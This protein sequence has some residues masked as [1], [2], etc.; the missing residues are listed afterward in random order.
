MEHVLTELEEVVFSSLDSAS[1]TTLHA[2]ELDENSRGALISL[3]EH[4]MSVENLEVSACWHMVGTH[5]CGRVK[6]SE[7]EHGYMFMYPKHMLQ[8]G[9]VEFYLEMKSDNKTL[10]TTMLCI[11]IEPNYHYWRHMCTGS[12]NSGSS[13][14]LTDEQLKTLAD[15]VAGNISLNLE[16]EENGN[17]YL[18]KEN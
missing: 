2:R 8:A 17:L 1:P 3:P 11:E 10:T 16:L 13:A 18:I 15:K 4:Y 14:S 6:L 7:T 9:L 12:N 5:Y